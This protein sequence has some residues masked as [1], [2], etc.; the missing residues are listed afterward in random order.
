MCVSEEEVS[1][2]MEELEPR[3]LRTS[4][5]LD[6]KDEGESSSG[7]QLKQGMITLYMGFGF[8]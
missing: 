7:C 6:Q 2:Q 4:T 1:R 8:S 5:V 3:W